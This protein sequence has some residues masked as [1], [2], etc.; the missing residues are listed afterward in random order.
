MSGILR[1]R[2]HSLVVIYLQ[3]STQASS[4]LQLLRPAGQS[5]KT[6]P[7]WLLHAPANI[8]FEKL[9]Y[10]M[11]P[12]QSPSGYAMPSKHRKK[13]PSQAGNCMKVSTPAGHGLLAKQAHYNGSWRLDLP[14]NIAPSVGR[15]PWQR[16]DPPRQTCRQR[17]AHRPPAGRRSNMQF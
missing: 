14:G 3:Q 8:A 1:N 16:S 5:R 15:H 12:V 11:S 4:K 2:R 7:D 13:A 10:C 17:S 6:E 9:G